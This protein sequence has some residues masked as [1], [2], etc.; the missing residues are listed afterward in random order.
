M[1]GARI[2]FHRFAEMEKDNIFFEAGE[3]EQSTI[4]DVLAKIGLKKENLIYEIRAFRTL[5]LP[6]A[7]EEVE[8]YWRKKGRPRNE[9]H[10]QVIEIFSEIG[11]PADF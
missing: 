4:P 6:E 5:T 9:P 1:R 7:A 2:V 11:K 10:D 8:S 3:F